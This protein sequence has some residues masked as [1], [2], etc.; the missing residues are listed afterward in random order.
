MTTEEHKETHVML[1][2][3]LDMLLADFIAHT[4]KLPSKTTITEL[5]EW[6]YQQTIEPTEGGQYWDS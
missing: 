4:G 3:G 5:I 6:S 2:R 1:H